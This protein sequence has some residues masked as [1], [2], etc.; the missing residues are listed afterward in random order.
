MGEFLG[1]LQR[2]AKGEK[3]IMV[4]APGHFAHAC[5]LERRAGARRTADSSPAWKGGG[6]Q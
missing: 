2:E 4:A 1:S 5:A 3:I 6:I